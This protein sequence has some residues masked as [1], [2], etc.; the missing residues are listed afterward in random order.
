MTL[1]RNLINISQLMNTLAEIKKPQKRWTPVP[2]TVLNYT[3]LLLSWS[4]INLTGHLCS[5]K[6][7]T[8]NWII[9]TLQYLPRRL[10]TLHIT[11]WGM[12]GE[13]LRSYENKWEDY[14]ICHALPSDTV[15]INLQVLLW[16]ESRSTE[17]PLSTP[18]KQLPSSAGH[19][20]SHSPPGIL[21][22]WNKDMNTKKKKQYCYT[23]IS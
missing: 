17:R 3:V 11:V 22:T 4:I 6:M 18:D 23:Q 2:G 7:K 5:V 8:Y 13:L 15:A 19:V 1:H 10:E 12:H 9:L 14:F 16:S 21:K 20:L